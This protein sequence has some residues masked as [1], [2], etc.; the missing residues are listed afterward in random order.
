MT[1]A[2][3]VFESFDAFYAA[4]SPVGGVI[5]IGMLLTELNAR[6]RERIGHEQNDRGACM[7]FW[8]AM[9]SDTEKGYDWFCPDRIYQDETVGWRVDGDLPAVTIEPSVN[10]PG[11]YHG[12]IT[13]GR[14]GPDCEGRKFTPDGRLIR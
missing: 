7:S 9:P 1:W 13:A 8:V 12:R 6:G 4:G 5:R 14:I 3:R 2:L 10:I 11:V